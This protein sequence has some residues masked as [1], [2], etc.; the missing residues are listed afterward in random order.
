MHLLPFRAQSSGNRQHHPLPRRATRQYRRDNQAGTT[1]RPVELLP[2]QQ[3]AKLIR[4]SG[5]HLLFKPNAVRTPSLREWQVRVGRRIDRTTVPR[6]KIQNDH[7]TTNHV[8]VKVWMKL[9]EELVHLGI[10]SIQ[11]PLST[12]RTC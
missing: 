2:P 6:L 10:A 4:L 7:T 12:T 3:S 11:L 8:L 9:V 1:G 5:S